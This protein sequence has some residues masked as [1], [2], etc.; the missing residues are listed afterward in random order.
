MET[1]EHEVDV[2]VCCVI[3]VSVGFWRWRRFP[4]DPCGPVSSGDGSEEKDKQC[5]GGAG[6]RRR[7]DQI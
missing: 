7:K 2:H 3:C 4:R 6:G 1:T 5:P